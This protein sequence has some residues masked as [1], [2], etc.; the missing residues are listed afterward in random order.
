MVTRF[1]F[2]YY[3]FSGTASRLA[4]SDAC[5]RVLG[6]EVFEW[7]GHLSNLFDLHAT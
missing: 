4:V 5:K 1:V 2:E 3:T 6:E 7:V